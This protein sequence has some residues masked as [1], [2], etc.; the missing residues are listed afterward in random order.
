MKT[1]FKFEIYVADGK[2]SGDTYC[3]KVIE[4]T[5]LPGKERALFLAANKTVWVELV[6]LDPDNHQIIIRGSKI[7]VT[8]E[9]FNEWW[10]ELIKAGW[11]EPYGELV[12][13][14]GE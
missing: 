5:I 3:Q 4:E 8:Q 13:S 9:E 10:P 11:E 7:E 12:A 14:P 2:F 1:I 6:L